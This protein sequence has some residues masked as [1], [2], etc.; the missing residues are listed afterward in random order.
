MNAGEFV[1]T[2]QSNNDVFPVVITI[3]FLDT[4]KNVFEYVDV[5]Y[6]S[7]LHFDFS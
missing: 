2:T 5:I 1:E 3:F 6:R 7:V 4:S